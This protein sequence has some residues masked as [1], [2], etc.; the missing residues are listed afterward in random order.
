MWNGTGRIVKSSALPCLLLIGLFGAPQPQDPSPFRISVNA[1]LVVLP[2]TVLDRKGQPVSDLRQQDFEV[3]ED[4]VR[5][6]IG[7]FLHAD[8]PVTVGLVVDHSGSMRSKLTEVIAAARSFVQYSNPEDQMFVVNFNDSVTLGLPDA[9]RFTNRPDELALAIFN[10]P[11]I[12]RTKLYDAV[13]E[14]RKL[15]DA[16]SRDKKVMLIISDGGDN[17]STRSLAETLTMMGQSSAV[18]YTVG[19]FAPEDED[20]NPR[21][22]K[23][24]AQA[25]G[26]EAFFPEQLQDIV[27]A[28]E[29]I[30]RDI[31]HQ[32][33][34]GYVPGSASKSGD[35]RAIKVVARVAGKGS[36]SVRTRSGYIAVK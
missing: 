22:L 23:R 12:G 19:I 8:I 28:C 5:Q 36:F 4:G 13:A 10:A 25:T 18:V 32:Y 15:L 17:A 21:V 31:R 3:Y 35:F 11:V 16:G 29:R 6:S 27:T 33:T 20:Q 9:I 2:A 34:L 14:A 1:D 26:G 24:L 30:A 7:L